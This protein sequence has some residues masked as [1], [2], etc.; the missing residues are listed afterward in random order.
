[1]D[2]A[3]IKANLQ[4]ATK[5]ESV[6]LRIDGVDNTYNVTEEFSPEQ[7]DIIRGYID[8]LYT[9]DKAKYIFNQITEPIKIVA[10]KQDINKSS[11][12]S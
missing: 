12:N 5:G 7:K 11:K 6:T 2:L 10:N 1:M 3:Q 8:Y 4:F 9:S